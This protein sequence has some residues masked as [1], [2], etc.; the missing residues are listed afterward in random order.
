MILHVDM[1]AFYAAVEQRDRPEL[2]GKPVLVGGS[3]DQRGV[4]CAAS[5]E[6]RKFGVH[7]A[8]PTVT[9]RRLC[10]QG[11]F[12]PVRIDHYARI[13][14]QIREIFLSFT[15]LVEPLS[16]DEAFLDVRGSEPL[17]GP[18]PEI[19]RQLKERIH[20]ETDLIASVGV[21]PNKFLAKLASDTSKP[22]GLLVLEPEHVAAFLAPL[23]VGRIWGV[24]A[25]AE[26]RLRGLG[27]ETIGQLAAT[28]EQFLVDK[29]GDMG[30][31]IRQL[32]LGED[33]RTVV[34]DRE[35]KSVS[36]ETTFA[37]DIEDP[38]V[39]R[40]WLLE[41]VEQLG[42][43]LRHLGLRAKTIELKLRSAN[44]QTHSRSLTLREPTDSTAAIWQAAAALFDRRIPR[45]LL[46][47]RLLGV[48]ASGL[49]RETIVQ[50][51]LFDSGLQ[52]KQT[53]LDQTLD[54]IRTRYGADAIRRGGVLDRPTE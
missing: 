30:R 14:K 46:P 6:A 44:F 37:R 19:A 17:F 52:D 20:A 42:Q 15:P 1:D 50:K 27:I 10:P 16:L 4:V 2:R 35:A 23:P 47:A 36:T 53:A 43:R 48:G 21:A 54:Q 41:L 5:Y 18:A 45:G 39:L 40:S 28:P 25:K 24:G 29:F 12:L 7:S 32:A 9:A 3:A 51:D 13:G 31:H 22:N 33:E 8:M 26:R 49:T 38:Q 11:I 34:P